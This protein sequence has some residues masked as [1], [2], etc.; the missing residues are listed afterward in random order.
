MISSDYT[1]ALACGFE[2]WSGF[3][4]DPWLSGTL[5]MATY[6]MAVLLVWRI[7]RHLVGAERAVWMLATVLLVF[8]VFNTPLD[9]HGL[10]WAS[11]R[12][13]AHIQGWHAERYAFQSNLLVILAGAGGSLFLLGCLLLRRDLP[14]GALLLLGLSLSVGMTLVKGI[15]YHRLE[16]LYTRLIGPLWLSDLIELA[17]VLC[18]F[19][20]VR[21][22]RR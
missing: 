10:V 13:L 21:L 4:G 19:L 6:A 17:G 3:W 20:A 9:L 1:Q 22:K 2:T 18:I 16:T 8:Q 7:T 12:C 14:A 5:M 11:G 15:N